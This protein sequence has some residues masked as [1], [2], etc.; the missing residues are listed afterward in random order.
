MLR[1]V[2]QPME[3]TVLAVKPSD[4]SPNG[5]NF[6]NCGLFVLVFY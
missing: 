4:G 2:F 6:L 1:Q 5:E 3:R